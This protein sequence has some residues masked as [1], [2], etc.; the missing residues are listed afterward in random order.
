MLLVRSKQNAHCCLTDSISKS[1]DG[2]GYYK[3]PMV[4]FDGTCNGGFRKP[5]QQW[6]DDF[7]GFWFQSGRGLCVEGWK[8]VVEGDPTQEYV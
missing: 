6:V 2:T 4:D 3:W 1:E 5:F 7:V 8:Y